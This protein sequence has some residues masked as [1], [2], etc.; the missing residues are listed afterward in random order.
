MSEGP[1]FLAVRDQ[2]QDLAAQVRKKIAAMTRQE[3]AQLENE[4]APVR[5]RGFG[6]VRGGFKL[7]DNQGNELSLSATDG[8]WGN[9]VRACYHR[10]TDRLG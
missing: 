2:L 1:F 6:V 7:Y 8:R 9:A 3:N 10:R 4:L 5:Q